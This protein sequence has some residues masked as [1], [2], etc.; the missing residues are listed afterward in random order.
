[1]VS[2]R[3]DQACHQVGGEVEECERPNHRAPRALVFHKPCVP[4]TCRPPLSLVGGGGGQVCPLH[5][6][7]GLEVVVPSLYR[8]VC[9]C[10]LWYHQS[11]DAVL[12]GCRQ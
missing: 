8:P 2:L 11:H 3:Q 12:K 10:G 9:I 1:M 7:K 4:F 5:H 6:V